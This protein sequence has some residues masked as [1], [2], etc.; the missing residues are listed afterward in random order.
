[1][2]HICQY[3]CIISE[4]ILHTEYLMNINWNVISKLI[5]SNQLHIHLYVTYVVPAQLDQRN[6]IGA[7]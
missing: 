5:I 7:Q 2:F 6:N 1:M 4:H 3:Q